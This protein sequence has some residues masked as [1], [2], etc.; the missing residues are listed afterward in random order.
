MRGSA[1][2]KV[3][4]AILTLG[5]L[6]GAVGCQIDETEKAT[7]AVKGALEH[8]REYGSRATRVTD[9]IGAFFKADVRG[10]G[11]VKAALPGL[12]KADEAIASRKEELAAAR[13]E[14]ESVSAMN[15][16]PQVKK[17]AEALI[18]T[19]DISARVDE[20]LS[21]MVAKQ[22]EYGEYR[23]SGGKDAKRIQRYRDEILA[24]NDDY[25]DLITEQGK[26][27]AAA[28]RVFEE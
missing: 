22:R 28:S 7:A 17:A 20:K 19:V 12:G 14:L 21:E 9:P 4:A 25:G 13:A 18:K 3:I 26:A 15:V 10:V 11:D 1:I 16:D 24:I 8:F 27:E 5:V 6:M 23:V 2:G